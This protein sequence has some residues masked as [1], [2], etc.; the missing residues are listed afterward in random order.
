MPRWDWK[1][2]NCGCFWE[3]WAPLGTRCIP[4]FHCGEPALK[5]FTPT[6]NIVVREGRAGQETLP[7]KEELHKVEFTRDP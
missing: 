3:Q 4:C 7:A 5:L 1:C 2:G 6:R